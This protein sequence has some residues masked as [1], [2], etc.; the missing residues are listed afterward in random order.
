MENFKKGSKEPTSMVTNSEHGNLDI[1][2]EYFK[3]KYRVV[4]NVLAFLPPGAPN[5]EVVSDKKFVTYQ[6]AKNYLEECIQRTDWIYIPLLGGYAQVSSVKE[7]SV[8]N[9]QGENIS[10]PIE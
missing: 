3:Y 6:Q 1:S 9:L 5:P 7:S 10:G 2:E 8:T 4:F